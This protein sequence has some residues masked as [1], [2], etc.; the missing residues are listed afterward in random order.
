MKKPVRGAAALSLALLFTLGAAACGGGSK[1][2]QPD[3]NE[4][5]SALLEKA[6]ISGSL[7]LSEADMLNFY[8]IQADQMEA[9]S[10]QL[11]ADGI[12]A[13]EIVLV[14]AVDE[15]S[16]EAVEDKLE[17]RLEARRNEFNSYLPDQ[18][19]VVE[20]SEV[21]RDGVY[22]SLIISPQQ[23]ALTELYD[24]YFDN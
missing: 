9:F 3:V 5:M 2:A 1:P 16:A 18:Y 7:E 22:V 19:A 13:N 6:P 8:G 15:E 14:K 21:Q 10:A 4:V 24:S 20:E 12:T 23:D 17:N 11:A